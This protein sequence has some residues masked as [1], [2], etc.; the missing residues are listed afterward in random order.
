MNPESYIIEMMNKIKED[1]EGVS[2]LYAFDESSNFHILE[3][4]PS[5]IRRSNDTYIKYE[6]QMWKEFYDRFPGEDVLIS[7][8]HRTNDMSNVICYVTSE[9]SETPKHWDSFNYCDDERV[10]DNDV[11]HLK[12]A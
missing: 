11:N 7:E 12:A 8:P 3:V 1:V 4:S 5:S 9:I 2:L 10:T 6:A